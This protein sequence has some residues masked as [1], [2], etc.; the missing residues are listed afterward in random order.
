[1]KRLGLP[2]LKKFENNL[3]GVGL[4]NIEN[5]HPDFCI[6]IAEFKFIFE[7]LELSFLNLDAKFCDEEIGDIG[8][9]VICHYQSIYDLPNNCDI[10]IGNVIVDSGDEKYISKLYNV[11]YLYGTL[12]IRNT[13]LKTLYHLQLTYIAYLD[14]RKPEQ[15][16]PVIQIYSNPKLSDLSIDIKNIITRGKREALI[17]DN[18]PD[19]FKDWETG[20][21]MKCEINPFY[22]AGTDDDY[23]VHLNY[24]G[25]DCGQ[26]VDIKVS[27]LATF[28]VS[29]IFSVSWTLLYL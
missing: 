22:Y 20:K 26:R 3:F 17:Q 19:A 5:L 24:T 25:G 18:H 10:I 15:Q 29:V 4:A 11:W 7:V 16:D 6:T 23:A 1:M 27:N 13:N 2:V 14:D 9:N 28:Y 8:N 12:T 21:K